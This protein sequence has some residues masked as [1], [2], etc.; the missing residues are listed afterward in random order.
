MIPCRERADAMRHDAHGHED[1][2]GH[3]AHGTL[4]AHALDPHEAPLTML[5]P[6]GRSCRRRLVRGPR[7]QPRFHQRRRRGI[8][9][10]LAL[11]GPHNHILHEMHDIPNYASG[12]PTI[13]MG[14]GFV[15][16][17]YIYVLVPGTAA[18]LAQTMP[19]PLRVPAQQMVFRRA[20]R[21]PLRPSGLLDRPPVL[22]GRRRCHHRSPRTGR[23]RRARGRCDRP[24]RQASKRLHLSLRLRHA[25]RRRRAATWYVVGG[26]R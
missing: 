13:L 15:V 16:A 6:A 2:H 9:E 4:D 12:L 18:W 1:A 14:A 11:R 7:L 10:G 23:R 25:R 17:L 24:R 22:E 3:D 19:A 5:I 8:L 26:L 20:L 21:L